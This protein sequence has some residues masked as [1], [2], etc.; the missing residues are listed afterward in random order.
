LALNKEKIV[1]AAEKLVSKGKIEAAIK[2][3]QRII[4]DNPND[5][6]TLN[7]IGDLYTRI[8][9][10]KEAIQ[11]FQRI[12]DHF[13][14]DGFFLRAIAIL[15]KIN[16]L[17]PSILEVYEKLGDLYLK[18]N[19][20]REAASH[21]QYLADYYIRQE[22]HRKALDIYQRIVQMDN[23]NIAAR[24]KLAELFQKAGA[25]DRAIEEYQKIGSMLARRGHLQ[26]A[27][28]VYQQAIKLDPGN[29]DLAKRLADTLTNS[30]NVTEAMEILHTAAEN[31]PND[32]EIVEILLKAY[33][34]DGK[35]DE[36]IRMVQSALRKNPTAINLFET[37]GNLH[38]KLNQP[39]EAA[40]AM[41]SAADLAYSNKDTSRAM[42]ILQTVLKREPHQVSALQKLLEIYQSQNQETY[43]IF[44][45]GQLIE[46]YCQINLFDR[47]EETAKALIDLEP[48]NTQHREKLAYIQGK[49][50]KRP[51]VESMTPAG[52]EELSEADLE[53]LPEI[54]IPELEEFSETESPAEESAVE[55]LSPELEAFVNERM[56]EV[57][58]FVK[59]GLLD[60]AVE[61]LEEIIQKVPDSIS[62]HQKIIEIYQQEANEAAI[63]TYASKLYTLFLSSGRLN[64]AETLKEQMLSS[65]ISLEEVAAGP[66]DLEATQPVSPEDEVVEEETFDLSFEEEG[67]EEEIAG[68]EMGSEDTQPE[69]EVGDLESLEFS[70]EE[71]QLPEEEPSIPEVELEAEETFETVDLSEIDEIDLDAEAVEAEEAEIE[72]VALDQDEAVDL[73]L[74][75]EDETEPAIEVVEE[76]PEAELTVVEE[77]PEVELEAILEEEEPE[78]AAV[79]PEVKK[80]AP[81]P[82]PPKKKPSIP[83]VDFDSLSSE[84]FKTPK[85]KV[86]KPIDKIKVSTPTGLGDLEKLAQQVKGTVK[87]KKVKPVDIAQQIDVTPVEATVPPSGPTVEQLGELDFYLDQD[88]LDEARKVMDDLIVKYPDSPELKTR[89]TQLDERLAVTAE[90]VQAV[91]EQ[92]DGES[93]FADEE[94]FFDLASELEREIEGDD[95]ISTDIPDEKEPSLD[96]IFQQFKKGVEQQLSSEDYDTHYNLGIAYKEMSLLDE[97]ISE[98]QIAA[99]SDS[100]MIECCSMLGMCF[101][102]KGMPQLA[103]KWYRKGLESPTISEDEQLG[104]MY[105]LGNLFL[106]IGDSDN[107]YK[108]FLE[109][110]GIQSTYRDITDRIRELEQTVKPN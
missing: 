64:E 12:A 48:D 105:D 50:G 25:P 6:N 17:D 75:S 96:E 26:E 66:M 100:H 41:I 4:D 15:K 107:A 73:T 52:E 14:D 18:Q 98:F 7:R 57:E 70:E 46:A 61:Q 16:K 62:A 84:I 13:A 103:E 2:E 65:G 68:E 32:Q 72:P 88:L 21:F 55:E 9:R 28:K 59:Y 56:V 34:K 8:N 80:P 93:L 83:Q 29:V 37:K 54:Q 74:S 47:A 20:P 92:E 27:I 99:K 49:M 110:Y 71:A 23:E 81:T 10:I 82:P 76:E 106:Q 42:N 101:L 30:G 77:E 40:D 95:L 5:T 97:A 63:Q 86:A 108:T 69:F 35:Y 36:A 33:E 94:E 89:K 90:A 1:A 104:L 78:P 45:M 87:P 67:A 31:N 102:E 58:V 24:G 39:D 60:R 44:T 79:R 38:Y 85:T 91:P 3:Y 22:E 109:I 51:T 11:V 53:E 19:M 43:V